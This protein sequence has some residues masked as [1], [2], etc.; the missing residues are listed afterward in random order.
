MNET[1]LGTLRE[2][3]TAE[4]SRN[5]IR[6]HDFELDCYLDDNHHEDD[7]EK[8]FNLLFWGFPDEG[9][10]LIENQELSDREKKDMLLD[11]IIHQRQLTCLIVGDQQMG[12]DV[13]INTIFLEVIARCKKKEISPPRIVSIG[14]VKRP[15]FI[16][17]KDVY[18]DIKDVPFGT[19]YQPVYIYFSEMENEY[20]SRE[21]ASEGSKM[22][23]SLEGTMA[24]NH[25]KIFGCVKLSSKI[26][27]SILRSCNLKI[28]KFISPEKLNIEG[29]ERVNF[30]SDLGRWFLPSDV[31]DKKKTLLCFNNNFLTCDYELPDFWTTEYSEQFKGG[32]I[33]PE[34]IDSFI[35]SKFDDTKEITPK[36]I[37]QLQIRAYQLFR[38]KIKSERIRKLFNDFG[39]KS[40]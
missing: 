31:S 4:S 25:Q 2:S 17:P 6:D 21:F 35:V 28:F 12:K 37:H 29:I 13:T 8:V 5:W 19:A 1:Q 18:F 38:I 14:S 23:A 33:S 9:R 30:L 32:T 40:F 10:K 16:D 27:I 26:D 22:F 3:I 11:W 15:P 39:T 7:H 36:Q 34:Q 24:Q 20:P